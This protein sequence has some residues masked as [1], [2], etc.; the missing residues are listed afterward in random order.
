MESVT[1]HTDACFETQV[2]PFSRVTSGK[3]ATCPQQA[4]PVTTNYL[5]NILLFKLRF[6]CVLPLC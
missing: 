2:K 4:L 3:S 6:V 1:S 5:V